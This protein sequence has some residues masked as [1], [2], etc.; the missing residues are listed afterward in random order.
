MLAV[1]A[2]EGAGV[3]VGE[4]SAARDMSVVAVGRD[5]CYWRIEVV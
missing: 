5:G 2:D 1:G 4:C 3:G